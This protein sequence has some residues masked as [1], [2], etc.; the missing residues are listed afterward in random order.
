[1]KFIRKYEPGV[2]MRVR[3]A[4]NKEVVFSFGEI[5]Y[6]SIGRSILFACEKNGKPLNTVEMVISTG[7]RSVRRISSIEV[8]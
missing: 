4:D 3:G 1:M 7:G 6:S 8:H 2:F 5:F